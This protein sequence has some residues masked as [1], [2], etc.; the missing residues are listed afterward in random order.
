V[1]KYP[2]EKPLIKASKKTI[3]AFLGGVRKMNKAALDMSAADLINRLNPKLQGW[4]NH[5]RA[6]GKHVFHRVDHAIFISLWQWGR[7]R[8]QQKSPG[9]LK[10]KYF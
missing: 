3:K 5:H 9:W 7:R 1:R 6:R 4:T 2:N 10:R 8:H